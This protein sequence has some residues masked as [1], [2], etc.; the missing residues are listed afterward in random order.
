[1]TGSDGDYKKDN[2]D[3]ICRLAIVDEELGLLTGSRLHLI[4]HRF[5]EV[6]VLGLFS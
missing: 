6:P 1:M 5:K 4:T 3:S 2:Q